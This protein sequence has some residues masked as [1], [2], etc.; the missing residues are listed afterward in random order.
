MQKLLYQI[1]MN[2]FITSLYAQK[3][4]LNYKNV[5]NKFQSIYNKSNYDSI[6]IM[7][8]PEMKE[9]LPLNKTIS[10]ITDIK[11]Q[12]GNILSRNFENYE[13]SYAVFKV[14]C[15]RRSLS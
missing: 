13:S 5:V 4:Y 10:F 14:E 6:F 7:F 12:A 11:R 8:S 9:A 15:E 3:D 2:F 1:L